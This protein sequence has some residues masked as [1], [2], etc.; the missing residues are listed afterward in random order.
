MSYKNIKPIFIL[1]F[2]CVLCCNTQQQ[3][4][5]DR[6]LYYQDSDS[7]CCSGPNEEFINITIHVQGAAD[8]VYYSWAYSSCDSLIRSCVNS[9]FPAKGWRII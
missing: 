9:I 5:Q 1:F 8:K 6:C 4:Y 3:D 2:L 7:L